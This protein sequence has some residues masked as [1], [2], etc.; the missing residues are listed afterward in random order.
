MAAVCGHGVAGVVRARV[1]R[2]ARHPRQM[3]DAR[4]L[5]PL[6]GAE[7]RPDGHDG[8]GDDDDDA[9]SLAPAKGDDDG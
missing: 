9:P 4:P 3:A 5:P 8:E 6:P 2:C 1:H 7:A